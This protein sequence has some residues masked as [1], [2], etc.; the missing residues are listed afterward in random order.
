VDELPAAYWGH[1]HNIYIHYAAE[2]G[3][4]AA[5]A[6]VWLLLKV[7]FDHARAL[8]RSHAAG[9][10]AF[11]LHAAVAATLAV[12]L[13][14]CFDLTLG[15]SEVLGAYLSIVALGYAAIDRTRSASA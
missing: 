2:R 5:A 13:V 3:L 10:D 11:L 8:K 9:P 14:G 6:I 1:L 15:D 4:L 12:M 7:M